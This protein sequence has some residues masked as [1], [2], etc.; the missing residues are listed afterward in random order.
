MLFIYLL[1]LNNLDL[2]CIIAYA[3]ASLYEFAYDLLIFLFVAFQ[4]EFLL[5][6]LFK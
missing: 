6:I 1:S 3:S 5:S 2:F 4:L